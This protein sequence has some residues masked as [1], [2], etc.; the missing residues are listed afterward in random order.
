MSNIN[1]VKLAIDILNGSG[2]DTNKL[3]ALHCNTEYPTPFSDVNLNAMITIRDKLN[4]KVGY[5]DH[6]KG[7]EIPIAATAMGAKV[8]EKHFTL[9]KNMNGPDHLASMEP[10]ELFLMVKSIRN[11]EKAMG[12][13][14]KQPSK[15]E[16]KNILT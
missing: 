10:E 8:I 5:S 13:G 9:D 4:I 6:T 7:I 3:T 14:I 1:E 11:I 12:D 16:T 2:A 15:S